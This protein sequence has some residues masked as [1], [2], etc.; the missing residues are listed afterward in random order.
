MIS[1]Q[2]LHGHYLQT[3]TNSLSDSLFTCLRFAG[4][5]RTT[6]LQ[7]QLTQDVA[8][9]SAA[10]S[11]PAAWCSPK[12]RVIVS[13]RLLDLGDSIGWVIPT[14]SVEPVLKRLAMY[15]LRAKVEFDADPDVAVCSAGDP[16]ALA[17]LQAAGALPPTGF[18]S[19]ARAEGLIAVRLDDQ[20]IEVYSNRRESRDTGF[21]DRSAL[22]SSEWR[23][24]RVRAGLVDIDIDTAERYTPHMLNYDRIGALSFSK[25]CYTGQEVVARTEHLGK[26]KR[27]ARRYELELDGASA[28]TRL[29]SADT[30]IGEIVN[31]AGRDVLAVVPVDLGAETLAS[32]FGAAVPQPLPYPVD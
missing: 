26:V 6:F 9:L 25:G 16:E 19:V 21:D 32:D 20:R 31:V 1:M 14:R 28:G 17:S 30:E 2:W 23:R 3:E 5:D 8:S 7:G 29:R 4:S 18:L 15:R 10:G 11:L 22:S 27:R 13:G 24:A 12:G